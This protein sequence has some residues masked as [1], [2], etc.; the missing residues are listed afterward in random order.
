MKSDITLSLWRE[1]FLFELST[2]PFYFYKRILHTDV[3]HK[4]F[5]KVFTQ[6]NN[7]TPIDSIDKNSRHLRHHFHCFGM[8]NK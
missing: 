1:G 7:C 5:Q 4:D 2:L 3:P 6:L 8:K